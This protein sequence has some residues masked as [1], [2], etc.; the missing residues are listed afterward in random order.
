MPNLD[1]EVPRNSQ[2]GWVSP[3]ARIEEHYLPF[4]SS[5]D[6]PQTVL[7]LCLH[8]TREMEGLALTE[9][10][11]YTSS[12]SLILPGSRLRPRLTSTK[13]ASVGEDHGYGWHVG[14]MTLG[15]WRWIGD[16]VHH[17]VKCFTTVLH[18]GRNRE[19]GVGQRSGGTCGS[20][21]EPHVT[22]D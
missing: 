11:K 12:P 3:T 16:K 10:S 6:V 22:F 5:Q 2:P 21:L 4:T 18:L 15:F 8:A 14:W 9:H 13:G 20:V 1:P 7:T 19:R 17:T